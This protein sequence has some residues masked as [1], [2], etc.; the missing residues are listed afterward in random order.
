MRWEEEEGNERKRCGKRREEEEGY[1]GR[2]IKIKERRQ[3][4]MEEVR[5][6]GV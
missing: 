3:R 5:E 4:V 6:V 1:T 2:K